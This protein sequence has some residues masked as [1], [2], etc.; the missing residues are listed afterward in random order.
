MQ[1]EQIQL[2]YVILLQQY[3]TNQP[4]KPNQPFDLRKP[5]HTQPSAEQTQPLNLA[6]PNLDLEDRVEDEEMVEEED[7][8][9]QEGK[10]SVRFVKMLMVPALLRQIVDITRDRRL[11]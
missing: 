4:T 5:N 3:M 6:K 10:G 9:G 2:Q 8:V 7:R 11:I 1:V